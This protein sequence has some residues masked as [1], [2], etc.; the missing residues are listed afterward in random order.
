MKKVLFLNFVVLITFNVCAQYKENVNEKPYPYKNPVIRHMYTAD[1]APKVMPDGRV[2]MVTSVDHEWGGTYATMHKYHTFSSAD[3]VNWVDHGEVFNVW[4]AMKNSTEPENDDWALWAPDFIY[5]EGKYFLYYPVR[6]LHTDTVKPN[7]GRVVTSYIAVA[8]ADKPNGK[9]KVI[10]EKVEGT[11][12]I[13]PSVFIDDDGEKYLYFGAHKGAKLKDNMKELAN[14][15][16]KM[17]VNDEHFMEAIWMHKTRDKYY[18]SYHQ[19]YNKPIDPENPDDP[20]RLK[21]WLSYGVSDNPLGPFKYMGMMNPELGVN[22]NDGPKFPGKNYV[23]WRLCQSNHGGIVEYHGKEY[24]FYHTSA[25]SSWRQDEFKDRGT[26]TQRSVCIDEIKYNKDGSII[27]V[28]QTLTSVDPV[29]VK[30]PFSIRLTDESIEA[31]SNEVVS[32]KN[33]DLGSGYYYFGLQLEETAD[34]GK[35]EIRMDS[36]DGKLLGTIL[37]KEN[38]KNINGGRLETFLRDAKGKHN[39]YIVIRTPKGKTIKFKQPEFFAGSPKE[40]PCH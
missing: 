13:D 36:K 40:A 22:V 9:F 29:K 1:A 12:G 19:H 37:L 5:H 31:T 23:P 4:D 28:Q 17:E 10:N 2:W 3:M 24:L 18:L 7:G 35:I 15:S 6:I 32:Y 33:I 34:G 30:Q 39:I 21:S 27:P 38:S 20:D 8:V 16:I 14:E 25:L 26:W 11:K